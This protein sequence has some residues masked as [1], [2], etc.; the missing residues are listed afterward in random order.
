LTSEKL[1]TYLAGSGAALSEQEHAALL[2]VQRQGGHVLAEYAAQLASAPQAL[3]APDFHPPLVALH[4]DTVRH[5]AQEL[6]DGLNRLP[7]WG[8]A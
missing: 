2:E 6:S 5:L 4:A 7:A 3:R 8:D 1:N